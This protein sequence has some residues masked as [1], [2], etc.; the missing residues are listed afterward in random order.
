MKNLLKKIF[1]TALCCLSAFTAFA[2]VDSSGTVSSSSSGTSSEISSSSSEIGSSGSFSSNSSINSSSGGS[3]GGDVE[4]Q[5]D[6]LFALSSVELVKKMGVGWNLGN[7]FE[8]NLLGFSDSDYTDKIIKEL[9]FENREMFCEVRNIQDI[10]RGKTT[11]NTIKAVYD[12]RFRSVR[13]PISW[14]NHMDE[15][16]II[17]E[18]WM[19]RIQEVVD[20]VM[21]FDNM[22]AIINI[23]D[24]PNLNAYALDDSYYDKTM[25]LVE[26][27]W[28]QVAERFKDYGARLIF[29]N[30]NEPLHSTHKWQ[31]YPITQADEYR[32]CNENL[33]DFNQKFVDTVRAQGSANNKNRFLTVSAYGNIGYYVYD[34]AIKAVSPFVIP[35][36]TAADKILINIHSY[37]PNGFCFGS[38]DSWSKDSDEKSS[39]GIESSFKAINENLIKK[40][41]GVVMSEWGS[42]YK[43]D[44]NRENIRIEHA[45]YYMENSAKY[46]VCSMVWD[47]GNMSTSWGGEFFGLLNRY[48]ASGLYAQKPSL[49]GVNYN[50]DKLWYSEGVLT[51]IFEGYKQGKN[52]Q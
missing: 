48:K 6:K 7:T 52:P 26:R 35:T 39:S 10:Y 50:G 11:R 20:Y 43:N 34:E 14:S 32:E 4:P 25:T 27:V 16:G 38:S 24:T 45:K 13:I 21:S 19:D 17:N 28:T 2:C 22:F 41:Y 9:G 51:A 18:A 47:N 46:G 15:S 31:L 3:G 37:S 44:E 12:K 40:G 49:S 33:T 29:E 36:D 1:V 8:N 23:M 30:L 5:L 42:V